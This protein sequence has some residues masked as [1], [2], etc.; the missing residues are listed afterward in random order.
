MNPIV[1]QIFDIELVI[2]PFLTINDYPKILDS[3][4]SVAI[5]GVY[6]KTLVQRSSFSPTVYIRLLNDFSMMSTFE[7]PISMSAATNRR[8]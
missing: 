6:S 5:D 2:V 1:L 7:K 4:L 8:Q 3:I